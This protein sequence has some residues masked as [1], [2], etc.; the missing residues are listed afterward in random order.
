[1][2]DVGGGARLRLGSASSRLSNSRFLFELRAVLRA[3]LVRK[4]F[5]KENMVL[6]TALFVRMSV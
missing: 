2:D 6:K 1:M 3:S 5:T 4:S